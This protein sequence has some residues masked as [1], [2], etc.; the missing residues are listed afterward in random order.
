MINIRSIINQSDLTPKQKA[1]LMFWHNTR[2]SFKTEPISIKDQVENYVPT[3]TEAEIKKLTA[4]DSCEA[5]QIYQW[6]RFIMLTYLKDLSA[7]R[8][9]YEMIGHLNATTLGLPYIILFGNCDKLTKNCIDTQ[10]PSL[11]TGENITYDKETSQLFYCCYNFFMQTFTTVLLNLFMDNAYEPLP[12]IQLLD[13]INT[14]NN[15][16]NAIFAR[17]QNWDKNSLKPPSFRDFFDIYKQRIIEDSSTTFDCLAKPFEQYGTYVTESLKQ[18]YL[19]EAVKRFNQAFSY[20][21]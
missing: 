6:D 11:L 13:K 7:Q 3:F 14:L 18:K 19:D 15:T 4:F 16:I 17:Y 8:F 10:F 9:Y 2:G 1:I 21:T 12:S 20:T 5:S